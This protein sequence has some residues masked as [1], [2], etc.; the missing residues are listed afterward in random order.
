M[1][2]PLFSSVVRL[3]ALRDGH[4]PQTQG[5]LAH[6]AFHDLVGQVDADLARVLHDANAR[7]P[8]TLSPLHGL[9]IAGEVT[10]LVDE[11]TALYGDGYAGGS[12]RV[13]I[14]RS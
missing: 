8:F 4:I 9:P 10:A 11:V 14:Y 2:T 12:D 1:D 7:K 3:H 13:G 5:H 6:A